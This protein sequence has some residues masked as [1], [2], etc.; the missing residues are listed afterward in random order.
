VYTPKWFAEKDAELLAA[1][2]RAWPLATI[3]EQVQGRLD[4]NH[5]P[6]LLV[7]SGT[8]QI[9]MGH[10]PK[11]NP[12][13][14]DVPEGKPVLVIFSGPTA[15][16][17]PSWLPTKKEH[18]RVVPTW[19]YDVIHVHGVMRIVDDPVWVRGQVEALTR[20]QEGTRE[21]P[22]AVSD[23]PDDYIASNLQRLKGIEIRIASIEGKTKAS[24]NQPEVNRRGVLEGLKSAGSA[25]AV[26]VER[27]LLRSTDEADGREKTN[28]ERGDSPR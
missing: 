11:A 3:V 12:I 28:D 17:T 21:H 18:G 14:D 5:I 9:L 19:H 7:Q 8:E 6:L 20:Q 24:Q 22:W 2:I 15:Y 13:G 27:A 4:A 23:A 1:C 25:A 10:A 16:I 26:A